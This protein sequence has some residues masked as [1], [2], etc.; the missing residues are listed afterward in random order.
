MLNFIQSPS[1]CF[2]PIR[3]ICNI[4]SILL[5]KSFTFNDNAK[6]GSRIRL[7]QKVSL[8][9]AVRWVDSGID[10]RVRFTTNSFR[11]D[12][13]CKPVQSIHWT[14]PTIRSRTVAKVTIGGM[15]AE[16]CNINCNSRSP[17]ALF[18]LQDRLYEAA[19]PLDINSVH[20]EM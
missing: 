7:Q 8:E 12:W 2:I 6:K 16:P 10:C 19:Q 9:R 4:S 5:L 14:S 20:R 15:H 1:L 18:I 3:F 17:C 13:F 11:A